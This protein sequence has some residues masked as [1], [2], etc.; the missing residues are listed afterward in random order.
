LVAAQQACDIFTSSD[1]PPNF[2]DYGTCKQGIRLASGD[3]CSITC[4][5]DGLHTWLVDGDPYT[6]TNGV[7]GGG[8][9]KC[10]FQG[11]VQGKK[12]CSVSAW[13]S[14]TGCSFGCG[15]ATTTRSRTIMTYGEQG[16]VPCPALSWTNPCTPQQ[17]QQDCHSDMYSAGYYH[18][19]PFC[20]GA[21]DR[22]ISYWF[23]TQGNEIDFYLFDQSNFNR[24]TWDAALTT[25]QNAYYYPVF[26]YLKTDYESSSFIVPAGKCYKVV[27]DNTNVGPAKGNNGQFNEF[28]FYYQF[29][30]VTTLDGFSDYSMLEGYYQPASAFRA[31]I[32]FF[33]VIVTAV[34]VLLLKL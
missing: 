3:S 29:R 7:P 17:G 12:N 27:I 23:N 6:C 16:G 31:S 19:G 5:N 22:T 9:Q 24:Y 28:T 11:Y 2:G 26:A 14:D 25:P 18:W 1:P 34:L 21:T 4:N 33:G 30:G 32:S 15:D 13:S 10:V 8:P 20:A